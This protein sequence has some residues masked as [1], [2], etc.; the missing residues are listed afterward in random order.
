MSLFVS[1]ASLF[2]AGQTVVLHQVLGRNFHKKGL[3]CSHLLCR[4]RLVC[5]NEISPIKTFCSATKNGSARWLKFHPPMPI[6]ASL[7]PG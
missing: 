4:R 6:R 5:R 7:R 2:R 3:T 1:R